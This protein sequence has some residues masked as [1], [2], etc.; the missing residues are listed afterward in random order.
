M[1]KLKSS[2]KSICKVEGFVQRIATK[3]EISENRYPDILIS[4]TEAVCNA[5]VHGNGSNEEKM[6]DV[7][8]EKK[9][10]GISFRVS[11]E[12]RGFDPSN[13]PD[14]TTSEALECCGGRGVH[15]INQLSDDVKYLNN[16]RTVEMFFTLDR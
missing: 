7:T 11:D 15:I 4:L 3:Y 16:G 9:D 5:I 10:Q 13:V 2:P 8:M 14:P 12:G 1:L 6:V